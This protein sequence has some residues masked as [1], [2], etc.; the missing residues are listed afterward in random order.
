MS[1]LR[2]ALVLLVAALG[3]RMLP[4]QEAGNRSYRR[5]DYPEA[6]ERYREA[7]ARSGGSPRL[8]YNLGTALSQLGDPAARE[9]LLAA[10][11]A[12]SPELRA[13]AFYNLGNAL[14]F[15]SD[16]EGPG[17]EELQAAIEAYQRALLLD[18]ER[19]EARWNLE[20]AMRRLEERQNQ[21]PA[22]GP[23]PP[24]QAPQQGEGPGSP[25]RPQA[26][27][28]GSGVPEPGPTQP[29]GART[30]ASNAPFPQELAEQ[31]LRAVEER[32]RT[33]QREKL[34]RQR[35]R[36]RGPDW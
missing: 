4:Q 8:Q 12:Q 32:E 26:G 3:F 16:A 23:E 27:G 9:R 18:P 6:I 34:R 31:I 28:E 1:A 33:L 25:D 22:R 14:A 35:Q 36:T 24:P 15:G 13:R 29:R 2:T 11:A 19:E 17:E 30:D 10:L 20:L 7:I 21:A 5:G